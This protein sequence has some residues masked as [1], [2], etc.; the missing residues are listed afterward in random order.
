MPFK[1]IKKIIPAKRKKASGASGSVEIKSSDP[2]ITVTIP[3]EK[4][5]LINTAIA[6]HI[7]TREYQQDAAYVCDPL[8]ED[9]IAFGILCDGMGGTAEGERASSETVVFMANR[10]VTLQEEDNIQS[11]LE[12]AA[13]D[14]NNLILEQNEQLQQNSGT[15]LLTVIIN[16]NFLYWLSVGDS[17]IY[18]IRNGEMVQTTTDH[19]YAL[20]LKEKVDAGLLSQDEADNDPRKEHLISYI[21][22]PVLERIDINPV[23]FRLQA[24]D[25]V[26]LCSDGLTKALYTEEILGIITRCGSNIAEAARLLPLEALTQSPYVLDNTTVILMQYSGE[27][28]E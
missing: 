4:H 8:K 6:T 11:F 5:P 10:I 9:G 13:H 25:I 21:G 1:K 3:Q 19:N 28:T 17:R 7:G 23:P 16:K 20:E 26:L 15:T 22:A 24:N 12:Q 18:I 27:K 14:A 2:E